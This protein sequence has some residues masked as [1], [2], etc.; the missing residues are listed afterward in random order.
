M[1]RR[2]KVNYKKINQKNKIVLIGSSMGAWIAILL[3]KY[4]YKRIK[5]FI[6]IA[7]APDFTKELIWKKLNDIEKSKIKK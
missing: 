4:F 6:A 1:G 3:I 7:P 2:F 5:G